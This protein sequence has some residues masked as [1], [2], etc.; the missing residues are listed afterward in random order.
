MCEVCP[1]PFWNTEL[2]WSNI[3][4]WTAHESHL[5]QSMPTLIK[6]WNWHFL[7]WP[8]I[9]QGKSLDQK[10][11]K[12]KKMLCVLISDTLWF[13]SETVY[14]TDQRGMMSH[15]ENL[16][17]LPVEEHKIGGLKVGFSLSI[18]DLSLSLHFL[19]VYLIRRQ[20]MFP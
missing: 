16:W 7:K 11:K 17:S 20:T 13:F 3:L 10:W 12:K 14:F 2:P 6:S 4:L 5:T 9:L 19:L 8:A 1:L 15:G 18:V